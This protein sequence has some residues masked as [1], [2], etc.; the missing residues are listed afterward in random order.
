MIKIT[1]ADSD[2]ANSYAAN[3][4]KAGF[5][6]APVPELVSKDHFHLNNNEVIISIEK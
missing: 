4:V 1:F 3:L 5:F 6:S 2:M